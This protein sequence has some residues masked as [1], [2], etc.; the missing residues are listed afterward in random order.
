MASRITIRMKFEK[1]F[2]KNITK[3]FSQNMFTSTVIFEKIKEKI[4]QINVVLIRENKDG[5]LK[6]ILFLKIYTFM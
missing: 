5:L 1:P 2:D 4:D 3:I 6:Q